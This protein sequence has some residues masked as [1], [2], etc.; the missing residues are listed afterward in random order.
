M[1]K[2]EAIMRLM[3]AVSGDT[4]KQLPITVDIGLM[5]RG[6]FRRVLSRILITECAQWGIEGNYTEDKHL[7]S[8]TFHIVLKGPVKGINNFVRVWET[9]LRL[10]MS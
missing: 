3:A 2:T 4:P 1:T 9:N 7:L 10:E 5:N 6:K 8:S